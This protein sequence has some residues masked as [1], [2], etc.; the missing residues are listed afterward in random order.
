MIITAYS[1]HGHF[2]FDA[3]T[4]GVISHTLSEEFGCFPLRVNI[5][6]YFD[7]YGESLPAVVDVLDI[8]FYDLNGIYC[9]PELEWRENVKARRLVIAV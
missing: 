3:I 4:G 8:G 7:Y 5:Y 2:T 1:S 6:E 9:E